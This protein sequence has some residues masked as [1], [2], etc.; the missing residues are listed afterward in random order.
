MEVRCLFRIYYYL[1]AATSVFSDPGG[2]IPGVGRDGAIWW[3]IIFVGD[4]GLDLVF[5]VGCRCLVP[6]VWT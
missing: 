5:A 4:L 1:G 3:Q 2:F 6:K